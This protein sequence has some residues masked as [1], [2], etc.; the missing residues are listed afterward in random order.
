M[1]KVVVVGSINI[2]FTVRLPHWP[3]IGETIFGSD[4]ATSVGGKGANQAVAVARLGGNVHFVAAV[5]EDSFADMATTACHQ[6]NVSA[7]FLEADGPTGLAFIDI[8][9][10]GDNII[11]L[12]PGANAK[13]TDEFI[14]RRSSVFTDAKVVL[15][16]NEISL[17]ASIAAAKAGRAA[18]ATVIMDPA[19]AAVPTW[20]VEEFKHFDLITPNSTE[21]GALLGQAPQTL[22]E[23]QRAAMALKDRLGVD[24]IVTMGEKGV[25]WCIKGESGQAPCPR[26]DAIDTVAAGDC[27]NG[28]LATAISQGKPQFDAIKFAL[29]AAA[30]ATTR[31]G[32]IDSL[33]YLNDLL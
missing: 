26:V 25:A 22:A 11:R 32:A 21:A 8:G 4:A 16:Q 5:G 6:N 29:K 23:G 18:G 7:A 15:L 19:P 33:P 2:D 28:A 27:F 20:G 31:H 30:L 14:D 9:P 17:C 3:A 10:N 12:S 1:S 13:L 24:A